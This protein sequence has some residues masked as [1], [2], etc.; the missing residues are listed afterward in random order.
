MK[1]LIKANI[2]GLAAHLINGS[3]LTPGKTVGQKVEIKNNIAEDLIDRKLAEEIGKPERT[4]QQPDKVID[5]APVKPA[6]VK[7][8]SVKKG[9]K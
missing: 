1:V 6:K 2:S 3:T 4:I 5:I 9:K 7:K 8:K